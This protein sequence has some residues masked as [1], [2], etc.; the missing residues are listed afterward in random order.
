M[1]TNDQINKL[2]SVSQQIQSMDDSVMYI[3]NRLISFYNTD[4]EKQDLLR[5]INHLRYL[6]ARVDITNNLSENQIIAY[7]DVIQRAESI[8]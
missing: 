4:Q 6:L 1:N 2:I 8:L 3:E 7:N 5:N